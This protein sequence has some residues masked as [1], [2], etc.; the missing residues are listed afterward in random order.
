MRELCFVVV[1]AVL[2]VE[3]VTVSARL[4]MLAVGRH[5]MSYQLVMWLVLEVLL[6][7]V[8]SIDWTLVCIHQVAGTKPL[9]WVLVPMALV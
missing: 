8:L 9:D 5:C 4:R 3:L 6:A 2:L 1:S 7:L